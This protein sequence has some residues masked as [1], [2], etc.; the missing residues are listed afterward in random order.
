MFRTTC[1]V[2]TSAAAGFGLGEELGFGASC[3]SGGAAEG[4]PAQV[5]RGGC[6]FPRRGET[7][8]G[9]ATFSTCDAFRFVQGVNLLRIHF[10][11]ANP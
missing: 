5:D 8:S 7:S 11:A 4:N 3:G 10:P 2:K 6:S 1:L 9:L